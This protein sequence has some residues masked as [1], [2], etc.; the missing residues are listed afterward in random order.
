MERTADVQEPSP[1]N[2]I[3][4]GELEPVGLVV[5]FATKLQLLLEYARNL[6]L[7]APKAWASGGT[8]SMVQM[9]VHVMLS[10][11]GGLKDATPIWGQE[12]MRIYESESISIFLILH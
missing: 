6:S 5:N 2:K 11:A 8:A 9:E 7:F 3:L 4:H 10:K 1:S 12:S